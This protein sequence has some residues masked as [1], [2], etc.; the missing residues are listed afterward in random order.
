L[1]DTKAFG[2]L[3]QKYRLPLLI[4][5]TSEVAVIS[6]VEEF[7]SLVWP[8]AGK[9]VALIVAIEMNLEVLARRVLTLKQPV[10]DRGL[11]G[12]GH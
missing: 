8:L 3:L 11:S 1:P 12:G 7:A 9:E 10:L 6:P 2:L 5:K 4:A